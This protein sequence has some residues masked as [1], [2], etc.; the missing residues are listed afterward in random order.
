V[1]FKSIELSPALSS[2]RGGTATPLRSSPFGACSSSPLRGE[3]VKMIPPPSAAEV[4]GT[5]DYLPRFLAGKNAKKS[6]PKLGEEP[7]FFCNAF[8]TENYY[9][10]HS[11][12][13][14]FFSHLV[15]EPRDSRQ[16]STPTIYFVAPSKNHPIL[17]C[18]SGL[19]LE[20]RHG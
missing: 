13:A 12:S 7:N 4:H 14:K 1:L 3:A 2:L 11:T 18:R 15:Q 8:S 5:N 6:H 16:A 17:Q 10:K 20:T 9:L 19:P